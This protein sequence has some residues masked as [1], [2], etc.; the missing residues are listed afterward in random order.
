MIALLSKS[1]PN[2]KPKRRKRQ[3]S[4]GKH[5]PTALLQ[6]SAK[7]VPPGAVRHIGLQ[8]MRLAKAE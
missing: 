6:D 3:A 1:T 5:Q 7:V 4:S 8:E 2:S